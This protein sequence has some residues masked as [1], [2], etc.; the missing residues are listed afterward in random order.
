MSA[1]GPDK[2]RI[3]LKDDPPNIEPNLADLVQQEYTPSSLAF[4][5]N[6]CAIPSPDQVDESVHRI[7]IDGAV[8]KPLELSLDDL[9][10]FPK[11]EVVAALQ[12]AGNRR[13][14]LEES[15]GKPV[16]GIKWGE[17]TA[18]NAKWSGALL[19]DVLQNVQFNVPQTEKDS[20]HVCFASH[21]ME[22]EEDTWYGSSIPLH[23]ALDSKGDVLLAY[24]MNGSE[25][26][27][28]H[29]YPVRVIV[30]GH[31]GARSVKW[32]DQITIANAESPN[33]YQQHDY[34]V[35]PPDVEDKADVDWS[36]IPALQAMPINSVICTP[37]S[38]EA[39]LLN[40]RTTFRGY[41]LGGE[42][43]AVRRVQ[44]SSDDGQT[45][46]E[47]R[48]TYQEGRWS[49]TLWECELDGLT[50]ASK[51]V[52]KAM[53]ENGHEQPPMSQWN[54]RGVAM[55]GFDRVENLSEKQH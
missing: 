27:I 38:G 4:S 10:K 8:A 36:K 26:T 29:G 24:E 42:G 30:P 50:P 47:A 3:V 33:F 1:D 53:N 5:R 46:K 25:L 31:A 11:I 20:W 44:L 14:A 40:G 37:S 15:A 34:K 41:A 16:E 19:R 9:R 13:A 49:W 2:R 35:L 39:V 12:C 6:H 55:N 52:C 21:V 54:L 22:C 28:E 7:R 45:W 43:G 18:F 51:I 23:K 17:G 32:L 48:I